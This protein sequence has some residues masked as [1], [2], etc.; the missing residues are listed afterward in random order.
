MYGNFVKYI[1]CSFIIHHTY[2]IAGNGQID[3]E[4]FVFLMTSASTKESRD[5]GSREQA[6]LREAFNVFDQNGDGKMD[7]INKSATFYDG[8]N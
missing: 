4:E 2:I 1:K 8:D 5:C 3:F 6:E 7:I